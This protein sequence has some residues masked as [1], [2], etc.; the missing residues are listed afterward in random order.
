MPIC[1][2]HMAIACWPAHVLF[3]HTPDQETDV[4]WLLLA[5]AAP[6]MTAAPSD[7]DLRA[8]FCAGYWSQVGP[9]NPDA[10]P[11]QFRGQ[12][13][14]TNTEVEGAR[15]R[16]RAYL[17]PRLKYL[18]LDGIEA[19]MNAGKEFSK[20]V[21]ETFKSCAPDMSSATCQRMNS[22]VKDCRETPFL[23]F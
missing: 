20:E 8:A 1:W 2:S 3:E 21:P 18:D 13:R 15:S 19:A 4:E 7:N 17:L 23:P 9:V 22:K 10:F 11:E 6:Y 12:I 14:Q 5:L 16:L